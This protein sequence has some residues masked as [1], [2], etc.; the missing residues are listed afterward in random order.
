MFLVAFKHD[1]ESFG[2]D[3]DFAKFFHSGFASF[4]LFEEFCFAV[5][6][7]CVDFD[8]YVFAVGPEGFSRNDT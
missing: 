8:G 7:A 6:V 1:G 2:G 5:S 4:L 3:V